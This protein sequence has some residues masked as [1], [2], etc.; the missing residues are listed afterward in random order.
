MMKG[1]SAP[2]GD[3]IVA[4]RNGRISAGGDQRPA[5]LGPARRIERYRIPANPRIG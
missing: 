5:C 1:Q 2:C 3:E 4:S